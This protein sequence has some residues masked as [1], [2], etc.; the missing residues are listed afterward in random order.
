MVQGDGKRLSV[1]IDNT[2]LVFRT[3]IEVEKPGG[4]IPGFSTGAQRQE[5]PY[6]R[7]D[8][9]HTNLGRG[10]GGA[11]HFAEPISPKS[12]RR[13]A[14]RKNACKVEWGLSVNRDLLLI[15]TLQPEIRK[16]SLQLS[17]L[18]LGNALSQTYE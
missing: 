14:A 18:K 1:M 16:C 17:S 4:T 15:S 12:R 3:C 13:L 6:A 2:R 8:W 5:N 9:R 11:I 10:S 7:I